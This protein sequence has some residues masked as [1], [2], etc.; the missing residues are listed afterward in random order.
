MASYLYDYNRRESVWP[1]LC[2][3]DCDPGNNY[4]SIYFPGDVYL[5]FHKI[6]LMS[7]FYF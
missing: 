7:A 3:C 6:M 1:P 2:D 5:V 4:T